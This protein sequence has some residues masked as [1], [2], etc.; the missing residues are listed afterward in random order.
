MKNVLFHGKNR[1]VPEHARRMKKYEMYRDDS[2]GRR[3]YY[4]RLKVGIHTD[5]RIVTEVDEHGNFLRS[6]Q[7]VYDKSGKVVSVHP[8]QPL[9]LGHI[10]VR[11][12]R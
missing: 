5:Y 9:D 2:R 6:W 8:K 11:R 7:E 4:S 1:S 10:P 12:G 3:R